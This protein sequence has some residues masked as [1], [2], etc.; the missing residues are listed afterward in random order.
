[1]AYGAPIVVTPATIAATATVLDEVSVQYRESGLA[2]R[3][4][5]TYSQPDT[6]IVE[7]VATVTTVTATVAFSAAASIEA[8]ISV[9]P[10]IVTS[11]ALGAGVTANY[12][13]IA[14]VD[15][16][17][18]AALPTPTLRTDQI[19][20]VSTI[21]ATTTISG[22]AVVDLLPATIAA[23]ATVPAVS[24]SAHATP[25]DIA[26]ISAVGTDQM[27][28]FYPGPTNK[29]PAIGLR[30]QPTP[31]AYALM[32]HYSP[33][34]KADNLFIINNSSVQN[35]MPADAST[36][37]RTLYGAHLPP[38]D[39]TATEISLLKASG[40]PIDVGTSGI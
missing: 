15:M 32:R 12:V 23:T 28:T 37:T 9:D 30:N 13:D 33:R 2:Y 39:L 4:N 20:S 26:V 40:F 6:G 27:Y 22:T 34:P 36:V 14:E 21:A 8:N 3:N 16:S 38:T 24:V 31:A 35:F 19:L 5:Y 1:M 25:G 17:A 18:V 11:T 10:R 29:T 7:I